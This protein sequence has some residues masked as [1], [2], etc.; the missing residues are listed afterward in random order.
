M[1]ACLFWPAGTTSATTLT[2]NPGESLLSKINAMQPGDTLL[3]N[4][5]LYTGSGITML[6]ITNKVGTPDAWF[7]I[8]AA[9]PGTVTIWGCANKNICEMRN[10]GILALRGPG[11][12]R[13]R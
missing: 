3:L 5:G 12:G 8:K 13:P 6:Y 1:A 10:S 11:A 7:T 2:A 4:P 9:Q